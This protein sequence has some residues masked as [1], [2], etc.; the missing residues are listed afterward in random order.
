LNAGA[1]VQ[2]TTDVQV[3]M[4]LEKYGLCVV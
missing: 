1:R 2:H 4:A 3:T